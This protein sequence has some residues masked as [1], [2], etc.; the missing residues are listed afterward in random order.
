[1][2]NGYEILW[3]DLA[4]DELSETVEYLSSQPGKV[5]K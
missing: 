2:E 1:M 5:L 4:L 3:T